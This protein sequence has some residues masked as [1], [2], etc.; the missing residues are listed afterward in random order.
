MENGLVRKGQKKLRKGYTTGTCAAA[1]AKA[2]A[3]MLLSGEEIRE[4]KLLVPAGMELL[5]ET[6]ELFRTPD[7][8]SCA[9]RK[10]A[11]D[12][13]DITHGMLVFAKVERLSEKGTL[14]EQETGKKDGQAKE[15]KIL[16]DGGEGVGR[17]TRPGLEQPVGAAAI[18]KTPRRMIREAVL[19]EA[20]QAG[21]TGTLKVTVSIPDGKKLAAQ[22]FNPRLGIEGGLSVLGTTGI[23][24]PMSEKALTETIYLEMNMKKEQGRKHLCIVPGNY[25][26]DFLEEE[27]D[28]DAEEAVKCSNYIGDTLDMA[29]LLGFEGILLAGH[30]GKF[31]KLAAGVMNTH[32]RMADARAEVFAAHLAQEAAELSGK[33]DCENLE[34]ERLRLLALTPRVM[35]SITTDEALSILDEAGVKEAVMGRI[36]ERIYYHVKER[37]KGRLSVE[38]VTFSR[39][40]GI[41]GKTEGADGLLAKI[42]KEQEKGRAWQEDYTGQA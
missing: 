38:A 27:L 13:P 5:L 33:A 28:L 20:K 16:L 12:D 3:Y 40:W 32:S 4:V 39:E 6:E 21:F 17:V 2:A 10:D 37:V 34:K 23:V 42:R 14:P 35:E 24:E 22:T 15:A 19:K 18:N 26:S 8:V 29:V 31:V 36:M 1:A 25:G 11:G 7:A 30:I 9:V 41:L